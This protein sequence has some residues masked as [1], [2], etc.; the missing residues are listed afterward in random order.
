M[1]NGD[2]IVRLETGNPPLYNLV[3]KQVTIIGNRTCPVTLDFRFNY[4]PKPEFFNSISKIYDKLNTGFKEV[5]TYD[6]CIPLFFKKVGKK[7]TQ[8]A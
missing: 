6:T 2:Y 5:S 4:E 3:E 7:P 1:P 8:L